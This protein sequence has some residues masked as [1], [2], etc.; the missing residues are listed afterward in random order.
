[1]RSVGVGRVIGGGARR[2]G[3]IWGKLVAAFKHR[4]LIVA[5]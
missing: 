2:D 4:G 5:G 1:M 3:R